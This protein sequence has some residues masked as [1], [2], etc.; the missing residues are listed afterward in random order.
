M[1]IN[2]KKG[3]AL[4]SAL[5]LMVVIISFSGMF[6]A[7]VQSLNLSNR[8]QQ[9]KIQKLATYYKIRQDFLD[10]QVI[11]DEYEYFV[12]IIEHDENIKALVIKRTENSAKT[13]LSYYFIYNFS[14]FKILAEQDKNFYLTIKNDGGNDYYYLADLVKYKEV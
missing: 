14:T 6:F 12:E 5:I 2:K 10:D 8:L 3:V 9:N 7:I 4:M 11:N 1:E 13:D